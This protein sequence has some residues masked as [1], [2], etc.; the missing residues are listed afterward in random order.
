VQVYNA[1]E[2]AARRALIEQLRS[3]LKLDGALLA[4][5]NR[6]ERPVSEVAYGLTRILELSR[7]VL[8]PQPVHTGPRR[9]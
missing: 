4:Q 1:G 9:T 3:H 6:L 5:I 8:D 2:E 7:R